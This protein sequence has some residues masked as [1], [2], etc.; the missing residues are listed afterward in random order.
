MLQIVTILISLVI[1]L[2]APIADSTQAAPA[3]VAQS[4]TP[5][6]I[7][8]RCAKAHLGGKEE[9]PIEDF[10][11]EFRLLVNDKTKNIEFSAAHRFK[12]PHFVRTTIDDPDYRVKVETGF[13]GKN[14]WLRDKDKALPLQGREKEKDIREIEERI[15]LSNILRKTFTVDR[16]MRD[17][18]DPKRLADETSPAPGRIRVQA[19]ARDF[20]L[21]KSLLSGQEVN[22][23]LYFHPENFQLLEIFATPPAD[24]AEEKGAKSLAPIDRSEKIVMSQHHEVKGVLLPRQVQIFAAAAPKIPIY[25]ITIGSFDFNLGLKAEDFKP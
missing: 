6:E 2:I 5:K 9:V 23:I 15:R 16:F 4:L 7:F 21:M 11:I 14:Y 20:V 12:Q 18:V 24:P 13:D 19:R 25:D 22:V 1:S 8:E 3:Q 17:L 10:K